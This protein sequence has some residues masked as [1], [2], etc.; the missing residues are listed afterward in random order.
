MSPLRLGLIQCGHIN[1]DLAATHGDYPH[2]FATLLGRLGVTI[3]AFD[4][5]VAGPPPVDACDGWLISG[6]PDSAYDPLPWIPP[7]EDFLRAAVSAEAPLV[8]ICFGH[9]LLAQALGGR[10]ARA[11]Q[12]WGVG[13]DRYDLVGSIPSWM[14]PLPHDRSVRLVASH[15]DQ[16]VELPPG[17]EV[18]ATTGHCRVAAY[19]LGSAALAL[20]P[21]PEFT[22]GLSQALIELRR[23][24]I[25]SNTADAALSTLAQ[26]VH[27]DLVAQWMVSF[28][29]QAA[30]RLRS[31]TR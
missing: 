26:P 8:A 11:A 27:S 17:A 1:P 10:V 25:G 30:G 19:T 16:V 24:R 21:H 28:L 20:Q 12:G 9:Q 3:D 31:T 5:H 23:E 22:V 4:V 6:S 14:V 2:L 15:Q 29:R 13:V 18:V 7:V